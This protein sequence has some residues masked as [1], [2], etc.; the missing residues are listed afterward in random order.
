MKVLIIIPAYNEEK[1]IK[2]VI[3]RLQSTCPQYDYVIINDGSTDRTKEI[4]KKNQYHVINLPENRG[5]TNGIQT[6]MRYALKNGYDAALQFDADGQ[7]LP[8]YIED[9]VKCME[10][11]N[12]DIVIASR[13][14]GTKMPIRMRT[15]GGKMISAAIWLTTEKYLTDP[16]SGMRLYRRNMIRRFTKDASYA[17]E[18]DTVAYLI[19][20]G[21]DVQE[22][23]VKMEERTKGKSYLTPV[24]ATKYMVREL[25]SILF[26]Q[27][28][29]ERRKV[30]KDTGNQGQLQPCEMKK[31]VGGK[32]SVRKKIC[33]FSGD[34]TRSGGTE[35]VSVQLANALREDPAYEICF[36][37]LTEQQKKPFY[38][39]VPGIRRYQLGEKWINP[40][41]GYLPLIGKL[42]RF[43]KEKQIDIIIDIY[44]VLDVLS[45]PAS[46][47]L[48]TR[49]VSWEHFTADF[50]L[51][52]LYRKMILRYSVKRSDYVVVLTDGDLEEYRKRLG[53]K[54]AI[55]RIYNPVAFKL[56]KETKSEKEKIIL[57]VGRL[58]P[59]KGIEYIKKVSIQILE[60]YPEWKW[61]LLGDGIERKGLEEFILENNLQ[62]RLILKGNVENVDEY[63]QKASIFVVTSK[64]EGLG[65][66]M[67]EAREMKVP[68]VSFDVKMG[69]RELIHNEVDGYLVKAFD[70]NEMV[71]KIEILINN[72]E[73][74]SQFAE[75][76][77]LCM[78]EFRLEKIVKQWKE[79]LESL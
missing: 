19:R 62:N 45:I 76:A 7:H 56:T 52:V 20:M 44:I 28:F 1:S 78:D 59:E 64:Y 6:G 71:Q 12:C 79:I 33:F 41:P 11:K 10:E 57:S 70:C 17:P 37:S 40:G 39:L 58:A 60:R 15:I 30:R 5:L 27:W 54:N 21:A 68:C 38:P 25:S 61:I 14:Y 31:V 26:R 46:R 48:K 72:P 9:M 49:V 53:R 13:Y 67:L 22:V 74:R 42:R 77:Y 47:G 24:N 23:K 2:K 16:T 75:K 43:L 51:S 4:C 35:R 55:C 36:M 3:E 69:P 32:Q 66:S 18:P 50:E 34:I 29:R 73:L 8:E 63:L 65:L